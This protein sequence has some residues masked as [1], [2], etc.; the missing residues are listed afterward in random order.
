MFMRPFAKSKLCKHPV[1]KIKAYDVSPYEASRI[2][3]EFFRV[4]YFS[5]VEIRNNN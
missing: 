2:I 3:L 1:I 5:V 4:S